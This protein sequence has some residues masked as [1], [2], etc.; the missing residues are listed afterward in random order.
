MP[1]FNSDLGQWNPTDETARKELE[2]QGIK[3]K[4]KKNLNVTGP[5][6]ST[7]HTWRKDPLNFPADQGVMPV[8]TKPKRAKGK[9]DAVRVA[10]PTPA[11][12]HQT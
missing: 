1:K 9:L 5:N 8:V 7:Q 4:G 2:M 10:D 6:A 11:Q 3:F 12:K